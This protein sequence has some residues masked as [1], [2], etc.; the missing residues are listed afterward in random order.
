MIIIALIIVHHK[1]MTNVFIGNND[2]DSIDHMIT[3]IGNYN[4]DVRV[5]N[6][7]NNIDYN[8][9]YWYTSEHNKHNTIINNNNYSPSRNKRDTSTTTTNSTA[10]S[11]LL[12][13]LQ[14]TTIISMISL[15]NLV[16]LLIQTLTCLTIFQK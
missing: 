1:I 6:D 10:P 2:A 12:S 13:I 9:S 8:P 7:N 16:V 14:L 5:I 15:F 3:S 4:N 11:N